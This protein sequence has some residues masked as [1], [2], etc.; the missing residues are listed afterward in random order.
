LI[1]RLQEQANGASAES[2]SAPP[3]SEP[4][5]SAASSSAPS[6][7]ELGKLTAAQLQALCKERGLP[8]AGKKADLIARLEEEAGAASSEEEVAAAPASE[9]EPAPEPAAKPVAKPA[10]KQSKKASDGSEAMFEVGEIVEAYFEDDDAWYDANV[11]K[12]MSRDTFHVAW[13]TDSENGEQECNPGY[14][15]KRMSQ[16]DRDGPFEAGESVKVFYEEENT[17][18]SGILQE[19]HADGTWTLLWEEDGEQHTC[20]PELMR[21]NVRRLE[22]DELKAGQKLK[23]HVMSLREYGLHVDVGAMHTGLLLA[24]EVPEVKR[25][26]DA[27]AFDVGERVSALYAEEG[28]WY[29]ATVDKANKDGTFTITWDDDGDEPETVAAR[30]MKLQLPRYPVKVGSLID[31]W[32]TRM[33]K[34]RFGVSMFEGGQKRGNMAAEMAA[35]KEMDSSTFVEGEVTAVKDFGCF[36][37]IPAPDGTE[38]VGLLIASQLREAW[39][40]NIEDEVAVGDKIRVRVVQVDTNR[41]RM[42]LSALGAW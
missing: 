13:V 8:V 39:V 17:W 4:S 19:E 26:K 36:V 34:D 32:V 21:K 2:S 10:A 7:A 5:S 27:P 42:R 6:E 31:V 29:P 38:G 37:K 22:L 28:E 35:F 18:Y 16:A 1:A 40:E 24:E 9:P 14:I 33:E 3:A 25:P 23:G 15:R 30:D 11:L 20:K 41:N 12:A